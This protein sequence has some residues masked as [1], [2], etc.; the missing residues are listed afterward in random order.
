MP[1]GT[2]FDKDR[3]DSNAGSAD[4]PLATP[5]NSDG[6]VLGH[7]AAR[8]T[9]R[10]VREAG[11]GYVTGAWFVDADTLALLHMKAVML[12]S[13][14]DKTAAVLVAVTTDSLRGVTGIF[15]NGNV[16]HDGSAI[17]L[18]DGAGW[19]GIFDIATLRAEPLSP[20]RHEGVC[21]GDITGI[22]FSDDGTRILRMSQSALVVEVRDARCEG[23]P[24]LRTLP[25]SGPQLGYGTSKLECA[26]GLAV[27]VGGGVT[28]VGSTPHAESK[29]ARVW[30]L[31]AGS[32]TVVATLKLT[33]YASTAAVRGD[34]GEVA[35]GG[36]DGVV[37]LFV[38]EGWTQRTELKEPSD[39]SAVWS[40]AYT[41]TGRLLIVGRHSGI[42]VSYDLFS[43][44]AVGRFVQSASCMGHVTAVA[45]AGDVVC[46]GG[47]TSNMVTLRELEPPPPTHHWV[48]GDSGTSGVQDLSGA[49]VAD[50]I[51]A[52]AAGSR[53]EVQSHGSSV[54]LLTLDL[55]APIGSFGWNN[56]VAVR[57]GGGHVACAIAT[58]TQVT[59]RAVSSGNEVF[60]LDRASIGGSCQGLEWSPNGELLLVWS[61][62]GVNVFDATG[63]KLRVLS[64]GFAWNATF[65][66]DGAQLA[67]GG[68]GGKIF[69]FDTTTWVVTHTLSI[70]GRCVSTCFD[71]A[72]RCLAAHVMDG[73]GSGSVVVQWLDAS[74]ATER[75]PDINAGGALAFSADERFILCGGNTLVD[76]PHPYQ[77]RVLSRETGAEA[78][79][80]AGLIPMALP[81]GV[82]NGVTV[83]M[84]SDVV[85][86]TA[87]STRVQIA[88][89]SAF[90]EI[91][92]DLARRTLD[93]NAW[94]YDQL[95]QLGATNTAAVGAHIDRASHCLNIRSTVSR[96]AIT[97]DTLLHYC[98]KTRN[99]A[100]AAACLA[101]ARAVFVPIANTEGKTALHVAVERR[102][103][104]LAR[105]LAENLTP[106]LT[107]ATAAFL[108]DALTKAALTMPEAVFSLLSDIE[109][110]VLVEHT[111]V[112]TLYHRAEVIGLDVAA[113]PMVEMDLTDA[114][115]F[116][117][118]GAGGLG[119]IGGFDLA[120]WSGTLPSAEVQA[121]NTPVCFKTLM[122]PGLAGDPRDVIGGSAFH[123]IV[124]NCDASV[125]ES[126]ILQYVIQ[127]KFETNVLPML[128]R[129]VLLYTGATLLASAT[130]LASSRQL[131][132]VGGWEDKLPYIHVAEGVMVA[133]ELLQV[134]AEARQMMLLGI[135]GYFNS[136]WNLL[137]TGASICLLV[138]AAGHFERS[139]DVVH[140]FGALGVALKWFSATDYLRGFP[141]TG[142]IVRM[143]AVI[144]Q[145]VGPFIGVCSLVIV[146]CTFF[147]A[148]NQPEADS[149]FG[150]FHGVAG[151][152][153]PLLTVSLAAL[154]SFS[155]DDYTKRAAVAMCVPGL[156][157]QGDESYSCTY[158]DGRCDCLPHGELSPQVPTLRLLRHHPHAQPAHR[159][160]GGCVHKG[161]G[162]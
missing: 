37:G 93:D 28:S 72:G 47:N 71:R 19:V 101:P 16:A 147:F 132:D 35:V 79:W 96:D 95:V 23:L 12:Y 143:I 73:P 150:D 155:I 127:Y 125:F 44:A 110:M 49:A 92:I 129:E 76:S 104:S 116:E 4:N 144:T 80:S 46:V 1:R 123:A 26:G 154:G 21:S 56:P 68:D 90:V 139:S 97:G 109:A 158:L 126:R 122:L 74:G 141:S 87:P 111:T 36:T 105:V 78:D 85:A 30:R 57:P 88:V 40:L 121:L 39:R 107:D 25:F 140:L 54:L 31:D 108:T 94:G 11:S 89:G 70:G 133:T 161:E 13:L 106:D 156:L 17:C 146:G 128:R 6:H 50:G 15:K 138:G 3:G 9:G 7:P 130:T 82:I 124:A 64:T 5:V 52:L 59:C 153:T 148:I 10:A 45:R 14:T 8:P 53:L 149:A 118:E 81:R 98:A 99:A 162:E 91:D 66:A 75:F 48:M 32:E 114:D 112:R 117:S 152:L 41:P 43:G 131:E 120:A 115:T 29:C 34:G 142:P 102:E 151:V 83:A 18:C 119:Y 58:G 67:A 65:S 100:L 137:D 24:L 22:A 135:K 60:S 159:D 157:T 42:F 160:H 86:G 62:N 113:L 2:D 136:V 51:V 84:P 134:A 27:A 145:D 38:A 61:S 20:P 55:G 63:A 33:V 69:L 77:L 103:Q